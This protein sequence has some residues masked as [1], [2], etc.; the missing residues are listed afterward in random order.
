M[1]KIYALIDPRTKIICYIGQ[2]KNKLIIRLNQHNNPK[3]TN[4]SKIAKLGRLLKRNNLKFTIKLLTE[5]QTKEECNLAEINT[6]SEYKN[7]DYKLKNLQEGGHITKNNK[8]SIEKAKKTRLKNKK[9]GLHKIQYGESAS[10]VKFNE[11]EILSIY[12]LIKKFYNNNEIKNKL[13]LP[14]NITTIQAIRSGQNWGHLW[15][16][17]FTKTIPSLFSLPNGISP[18]IKLKIIDLIVKGY[19][20]E[21]IGSKFKRI[22]GDLKRVNG[23]SIWQKV[24]EV[25][26]EYYCKIH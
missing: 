25:Y 10:F 26:N 5:H 19:T 11:K 8:N 3:S 7:N 2:T 16:L 24:W 20:L 22:K 18:R 9:L 15:S 13:N 12:N 1:Y 14:Y 21:H 17:N 4:Y 6:I 23:K